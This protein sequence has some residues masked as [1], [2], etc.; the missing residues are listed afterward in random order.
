MSEK[1][2]KFGFFAGKL[3]AKTV[4]EVKPL[5]ANDAPLQPEPIPTL[6]A[7]EKI[8]KALELLDSKN[9][10]KNILDLINRKKFESE[11]VVTSNELNSVDENQRKIIFT[12]NGKNL[13]IILKNFST[14]SYNLII[15]YEGQ[16][17]LE[18][19]AFINF[20]EIYP[21]HSQIQYFGLSEDTLKSFKNGS[22]MDELDYLNKNFKDYE[23]KSE[24]AEKEKQRKLL[25]DKLDL[26]P[27]D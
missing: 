4:N 23:E 27:N 10:E 17:V 3:F 22:W 12:F 9:V 13:Q 25:A 6:S 16:C 7:E 5:L 2:N 15:I 14:N 24:I 18:D 8:K 11:T 26:D 21:Q 20:G 19:K 1:L